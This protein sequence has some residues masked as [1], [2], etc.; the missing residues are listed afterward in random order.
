[1]IQRISLVQFID[2]NHYIT[3]VFIF[4]F[5]ITCSEAPS[6]CKLFKFNKFS[7]LENNFEH[8]ILFYDR[9]LDELFMKSF[10]TG[11][12]PKPKRR[13]LVCHIETE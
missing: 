8:L 4:E 3:F 6:K 13:K 2:C 1:M 7:F 10:L 12:R 9:W 5:I 11:Q